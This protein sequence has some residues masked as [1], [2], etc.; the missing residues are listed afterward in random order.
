MFLSSFSISRSP[1]RVFDLAARRCMLVPLGLAFV[2]LPALPAMP[3]PHGQE[4]LPPQHHHHSTTTINIRAKGMNRQ[5]HGRRR[6]AFSPGPRPPV[7]APRPARHPDLR[8]RP[9]HPPLPQPAHPA[10]DARGS[11]VSLRV[12]PARVEPARLLALPRRLL[13]QRL[14]PAGRLDGAA[15][16]GMQGPACAQHEGRRRREERRGAAHPRESPRPSPP[17]ERNRGGPCLS[18]RTRGA[19]DED[20]EHQQ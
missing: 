17:E 20:E 8:G 18:G 3:T 10:P 1:V 9:G 11:R 12:L 15:L 7:Q 2:L 19:E 4:K 5:L 6:I 13:L 14:V 16:Q